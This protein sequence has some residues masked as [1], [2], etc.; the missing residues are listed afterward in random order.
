MSARRLGV[1][2]RES[3]VPNFDGRKTE[4]GKETKFTPQKRPATSITRIRRDKKEQPNEQLPAA[5]A[6]QIEVRSKNAVGF[7]NGGIKTPQDLTVF[8]DTVVSKLKPV[9]AKSIM[10]ELNERLKDIPLRKYESCE[11]SEKFDIILQLLDAYKF[12]WN[13]AS[14]Q[15]RDISREHGRVFAKLKEFFITLIDKYPALIMQYEDQVQHL[16]EEN[17]KKDQEIALLKQEM[18]EQIER[19]QATKK[20]IVDIQ[21][22]CKRLKERKVHYKDAVNNASI[23]VEQS[24]NIITELRLQL[25]KAKEENDR[26]KVPID[27]ELLLK[28][29]SVYG[30]KAETED[31]GTDPISTIDDSLFTPVKDNSYSS[32]KMKR[33]STLKRVDS[34]NR[35]V[36]LHLPTTA[37]D[38]YVPLRHTVF[39]FIDAKHREPVPMNSTSGPDPEYKKFYW[40]FPK[41]CSIF[42]NSL[43]FEDTTNPYNSFSEIVQGYIGKLY[44]TA[45]LSQKMVASLVETAHFIGE[46]STC[47]ALFN[48]FTDA[49]YDFPTFR[50]CSAMIEFSIIYTSPDIAD[51]VANEFITPEEANIT[52][53]PEDALNVHQAIFP[54]WEPC[55]E[56]S[57]ASEPI[58]FW[59]F[60]DILIQ[61]FL[62]ARKHVLAFIKHGLLISGCTD[63]DHITYKNFI[64][65]VC[66]AFPE[67]SHTSLKAEWKE[68]VIQYKALGKPEGDTI[69]QD[70]IIFYC[71]SKDS[72]IMTMMRTNTI[73]SFSQMY[74]DWN[75]S[76]LEVLDFMV[77]RLTLYIPAIK[78]H[79]SKHQEELEEAQNDIRNSLFMG[80]LSSAIGFYR[81][82]MHIIDG[83]AVND[84]TTVS[85]SNQTPSDEVTQLLKHMMTREYIVGIHDG[86]KPPQISN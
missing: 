25:Q 48:K 53:S 24:S 6:R 20:Y 54:F 10:D 47:V 17:K 72:T 80:D 1:K 45:F 49:E 81:R 66:V 77:K 27:E 26:L 56:L 4:I 7:K 43:S 2:S 40:V 18:N 57:D 59:V 16:V 50:F 30:K 35:I 37:D 46:Q 83:D 84:F 38:K 39:S 36:N 14:T 74:F 44:K 73:R 42:I 67:I 58:D 60:L 15:M 13:E 79:L 41:I 19:V 70:C 68:L 29:S 8:R 82:L 34:V 28:S 22:E 9:Q 51:L 12:A 61:E 65:F 78:I 62:K 64:Q 11:P 85:V 86:S 69:D 63:L 32:H 5:S 21:N 76:M 52:L 3:L 31:I 23:Q 33:M 75:T 71:V 55:H